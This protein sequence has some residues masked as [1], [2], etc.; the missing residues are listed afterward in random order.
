MSEIND[1]MNI[2]LP[3]EWVVYLYDKTAFNARN[4]RLPPNPNIEVFTM[5]RINDLVYFLRLMKNKAYPNSTKSI[6]DSLK[7]NLDVYDYIV[8]RK[9]VR[10]IWED[11]KNKDCG[12]FSMKVPHTI[13]YDVWLEMASLIIFDN[14]VT[15]KSSIN[16]FSCKYHVEGAIKGENGMFNMIS[17]WDG[18]SN[19]KETEFQTIINPSFMKKINKCTLRYAHYNKKS[20]YGKKDN[21]INTEYNR[22]R[23]YRRGF[24]N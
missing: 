5:S 1:P 24:R 9:G 6:V 8:M 20:G 22:T 4:K 2:K 19:R 18:K 7:I 13:S 12:S 16:G 3:S 23:Y 11:P 15:D 21:I 14:F 10:P 17:V